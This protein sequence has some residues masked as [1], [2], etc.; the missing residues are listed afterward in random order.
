M[1]FIYLLIENG[2]QGEVNGRKRNVSESCGTET[3]VNTHN[4]LL[5]DQF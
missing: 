1:H 2:K 4:A 5:T 3:F